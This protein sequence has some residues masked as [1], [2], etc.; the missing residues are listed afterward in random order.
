MSVTTLLGGMTMSILE[1]SFIQLCEE[2]LRFQQNQDQAEDDEHALFWAHQG[3]T[4]LLGI[5]S[6]MD[7]Y[8]HLK[9]LGIYQ[10]KILIK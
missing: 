4:T 1:E 7:E 3:L 9:E 2:Y 8:P 6:M 10:D 5:Q